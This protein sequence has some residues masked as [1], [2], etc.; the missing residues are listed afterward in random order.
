MK[1]RFL[2]VFIL[3]F[4]VTNVFAG[5]GWTK[6]KGHGFAKIGQWWVLAD[7]HFV[8]DGKIDPNVTIGLYN[9]SFYGEYGI[10]DRLTSVVYFPFFSRATSNNVLSETTGQV[11]SGQEGS[12]INGIGDADLSLKY[13][14]IQDSKIVLSTML[15]LGLPLGKDSGGT[16]GILQTGDGEFN[17]LIQFDA[18]TSHK[19]SDKVNSYASLYAGVNN[20]TNGFSDEFRF[21]GE[22]GFILNEKVI[23]IGRVYGVESFENGD[24]NVG[25]NSSSVFAN[26]AEHFSYATE[27]GYK[28]SKK[29]GVTATYLKA[30]SGQ[31]IFA[32]A[33]YSVGVFYEW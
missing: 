4:C 10:T 20:R 14:L 23:L 16:G 12:A 32:N 18:S 3:F 21:G 17:Q 27:V 24:T 28:F 7:Q 1:S 6:Q 15:T 8:R 5:G 22:L 29:F 30:F 9:T 31:L 2:V 19:F 25:G 11:K 13:G 33:A 26:N